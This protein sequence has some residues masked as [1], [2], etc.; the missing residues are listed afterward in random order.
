MLT[1]HFLLIRILGCLFFIFQPLLLCRLAMLVH[2][3][4]LLV[5]HTDVL[6]LDDSRLLC[7]KV[8]AQAVEALA[9][10]RRR[11]RTRAWGAVS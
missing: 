9:V 3:S 4:L 5:R 10:R 7:L 2:L 6:E 11:G 8:F 1:E